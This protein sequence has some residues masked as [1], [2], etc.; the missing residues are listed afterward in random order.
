MEICYQ[1]QAPAAFT[2]GTELQLIYLGTRWRFVV[3]FTL[4]LL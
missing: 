1:I 4:Q 2:M 3:R